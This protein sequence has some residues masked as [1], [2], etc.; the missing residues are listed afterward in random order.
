MDRSA[1]AAAVARLR[2]EISFHEKK[3][4]LDNDPQISDAEFDALMK[5][6]RRLEDEHPELV[7]PESP[8]QRVGGKP[9][10]GFLTVRHRTPMLSLDNVYSV[11]EF[12]EFESRVHKLLPDRRIEYVAELKIDGLSVSVLYRD[13]RLVQAVT[14]GDGIQGDDVTG[15]ART[16]KI[17]PLLIPER[18]EVEVRGEIYLPFSSFQ[19]INK[20]RETHEEPPFANPRNAAAGSIRL[21]DPREV[22]TRR[23]DAFFYTLMIEGTESSAQWACLGAIKALGFKTNPHSRLCPDAAAV[24][25]YW[26]EWTDRREALDYDVDGVVIK[27]NDESQRRELGFTAKF[28]RGAISFKFPARQATTRLRDII[29]Q[30]GRTGALTP[31]AV[32]DPVKIS[33]TTVSRATLH[34][35]DE[36]RRK[37]IRVGDI[38][39][40]E[41]SGDVI[42]RI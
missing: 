7:V 8:T 2:E 18:R 28:P 13:G 1:T 14:R 20:A 31:V 35:E 4:Y 39:L 30:V 9:A 12:E 34:N 5:E 36:I 23:L 42:P 32:L 3:Y 25:A 37:E 11:E 6:L 22:A 17:L 29:V 24:T 38:V 26:R 16:I 21:L 41:R 15:N 10:E 19:E 40:V 27:V 33:G